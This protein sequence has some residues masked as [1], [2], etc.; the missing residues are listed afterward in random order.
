[1]AYLT[2]LGLIDQPH[3]SA[4]R[5]PLGLGY[6]VYTERILPE[7]LTDFEKGFISKGISKNFSDPENL[8]RNTAK[9]L[10]ET[11]GCTIIVTAPPNKEAIINSIRFIQISARS[12]ML[13]LVTSF[14]LVENRI[15]NCRFEINERILSV[16]SEAVHEYVGSPIEILRPQNINIAAGFHGIEDFISPAIEML[17]SAAESAAN[18]QMS[19]R[20]QHNLFKNFTAEKSIEILEF[21]QKRSNVLDLV[22]S[23]PEGIT[24]GGIDVKPLR[25]TGIV[26]SHYKAGPG[27]G[28]I[29][30]IGPAH[31]DYRGILSKLCYSSNL[32]EKILDLATR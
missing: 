16:F 27:Y 28:T 1:M 23:L 10:A 7:K 2:I 21:L 17:I 6:R 29:A 15:F 25:G 30:T 26:V 14:G 32:I 5:V 8:I 9:T 4:G 19:I 22:E 31:M 11:T 18:P 13:I 24:V 20:G 3:I 12:A